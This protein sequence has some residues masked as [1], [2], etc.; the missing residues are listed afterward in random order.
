MAGEGDSALNWVS[1][2]EHTP[3]SFQAADNYTLG[4]LLNPADPTVYSR[5]AIVTTTFF[6]GDCGSA[7]I[8]KRSTQSIEAGS[9]GSFSS[10]EGQSLG[11]GCVHI[12][13]S[14]PIVPLNAHI[15]DSGPLGLGQYP[16]EMH[17]DF[18]PVDWSA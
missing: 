2:Y 5:P 17:M 4:Y 15:H 9:I 8:F 10:F 6:Y 18:V 14:A 16:I 7:T 1:Y 13:S 12:G 3:S 11:Y